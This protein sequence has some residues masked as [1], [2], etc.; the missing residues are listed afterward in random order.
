[1]LMVADNETGINTDTI[2]MRDSVLN[3]VL[4]IANVSQYKYTS[5]AGDQCT[6]IPT[7]H[8]RQ[9]QSAHL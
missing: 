1:M 8:N 4:L 2:A 5:I 6:I 3:K 7:Y 9:Q